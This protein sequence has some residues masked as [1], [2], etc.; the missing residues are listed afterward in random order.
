MKGEEMKLERFEGINISAE[1]EME[2]PDM[3]LVLKES[4]ISTHQISEMTGLSPT[5]VMKIVFDRRKEKGR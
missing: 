1:F 2:Q 3:I 4:G 5:K